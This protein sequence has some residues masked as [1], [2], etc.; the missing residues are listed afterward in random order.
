MIANGALRLFLLAWMISGL[1]SCAKPE[2][3]MDWAAVAEAYEQSQ[4]R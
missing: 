4:K 3:K 2:R 1:T